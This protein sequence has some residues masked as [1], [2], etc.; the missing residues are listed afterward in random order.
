VPRLWYVR[1]QGQVHGPFPL[2]AVLQ[3]RLVGR[4][5]PDD[6]LSADQEEWH[7]FDGWPELASALAT[8][9]SPDPAAEPEWLRERARARLRWADERGMPDRRIR[10]DEAESTGERRDAQEERR[11]HQ[12]VGTGVRT[13][14]RARV[15][16]GND[17]AL[18]KIV[19]ALLAAAALIAL[20][21]WLYGPVNPVPVHIR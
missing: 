11:A 9:A 14:L 12:S 6:E 4:I 8:S 18:I 5:G 19:A 10:Q 3:D 21:A 13:A 15:R 17:R 2:G 16:F 20:V 7:P 1:K